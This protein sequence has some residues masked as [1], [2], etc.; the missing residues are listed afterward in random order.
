MAKAFGD[1]LRRRILQ[2]YE[3]GQQTQEEIAQRFKVSVRYVGKL[4]AHKRKTKQAERIPHRPGRKPKFTPPIRE[5]LRSWLKSQPDL[6][7]KELQKKLE[8]EE[9][10]HSSQF[11]IWNTLGKMGLRLKKSRSMPKSKTRRGSSRS[12]RPTSRR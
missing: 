6:T 4:V 11:S 8:Q 5:R 9:R 3:E 7:L 2:C 10:L 1:E 12:A